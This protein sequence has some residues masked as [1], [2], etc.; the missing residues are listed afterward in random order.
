MAVMVPC[1]SFSSTLLGWISICLTKPEHQSHMKGCFYCGSDYVSHL[2]NGESELTPS[3]IAGIFPVTVALGLRSKST[4][5]PRRCGWKWKMREQNLN[6]DAWSYT[7][8]SFCNT[9]EE[10]EA[11]GALST[12]PK[13]YVS[14]WETCHGP[15]WVSEPTVTQDLIK[16]SCPVFSSMDNLK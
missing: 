2:Q 8:L 1:L 7:V 4:M 15:L 16:N 10:K 13:S 5:V 11:V 14:Q 6:E 9:K 3:D 12:Y